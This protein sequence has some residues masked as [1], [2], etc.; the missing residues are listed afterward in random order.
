VV[1]LI[2]SSKAQTFLDVLVIAVILFVSATAFVIISMAQKEISSELL[3]DPD[4][5][6]STEAVDALTAFDA[7]FTTSLDTMIIVVFVLLWVFVIV[8]SLFVDANPIF[9]VISVILLV[10]ILVVMAVMSNAYEEFISDG[11]IYTFAS[12][13]PKTNY[14]M[15]HLVLFCAFIAFSGIIAIYGKNAWAGGLA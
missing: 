11:D 2:N 4:F 12:G 1:A 6:T 13:F 9:L 5:S 8:S 7:H 10:I 3:A 15:E 14:I